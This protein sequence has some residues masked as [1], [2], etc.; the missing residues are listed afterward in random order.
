MQFVCPVH[1]PQSLVGVS[2]RF[3]DACEGHTPLPADWVRLVVVRGTDRVA[4]HLV[5]VEALVAL[6]LDPRARL[7]TLHDRD[8]SARRLNDRLLI[9]TLFPPEPPRRACQ[10]CLVQAVV[11]PDAPHLRWPLGLVWP[12]P[13]P[14][15]DRAPAA[16]GAEDSASA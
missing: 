7:L 8:R 2:T 3:A 6:G 11:P 12:R 13:A 9:Q 10:A 15:P 4:W 5:D 1:G 14:D 16:D